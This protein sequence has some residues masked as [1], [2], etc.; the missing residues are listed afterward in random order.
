MF[1]FEG[2]NMKRVIC[3]ISIFMILMMTLLT[4]VSCGGDSPTNPG[5]PTI[6]GITVTGI[7]TEYD[8][9]QPLEIS[10][11][12]ITVTYS[13]GTTVPITG[14]TLEQLNEAGVTI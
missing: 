6:I 7:E 8:Y 14:I 2:A 1:F 3:T 11:I 4:F 9:G 5:N 12:T 13:D 10:G